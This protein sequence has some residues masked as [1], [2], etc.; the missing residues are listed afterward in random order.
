MNIMKSLRNSGG[1][2]ACIGKT[3]GAVTERSPDLYYWVFYKLE[4]I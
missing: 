3:V 4:F 2:F 1:I